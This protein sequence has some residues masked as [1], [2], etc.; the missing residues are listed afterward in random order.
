[1]CPEFA[2]QHEP[3]HWSIADPSGTGA[4][5]D[6]TYPAFERLADDLTTRI[7]YLVRRVLNDIDNDIDNDNDK[8]APP[9]PMTP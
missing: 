2:G 1:M 7:T 5:D 9:C 6:E 4:S 3:I 8:G